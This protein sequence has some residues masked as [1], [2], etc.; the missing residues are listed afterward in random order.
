M[1][2]TSSRTCSSL[3]LSSEASRTPA[4]RIYYWEF[5]K[6]REEY[7]KNRTEQNQMDFPFLDFINKYCLEF[8]I[9]LGVSLCK[10][11]AYNPSVVSL[12][13][14]ICIVESFFLHCF[15]SKWCWEQ[16]IIFLYSFILM[17]HLAPVY[18]VGNCIVRR[19]FFLNT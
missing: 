14:L 17:E 3:A 19:F 6:C 18:P 15:K 7:N 5:K 13:T 11:D 16:I 10:K 1:E 12:L 4:K 9:M 8:N 2:F